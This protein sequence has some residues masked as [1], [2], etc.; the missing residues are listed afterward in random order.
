MARLNHSTIA[1]GARFSTGRNRSATYTAPVSIPSSLFRSVTE[2]I[3]SLRRYDIRT[4]NIPSVLAHEASRVFSDRLVGAESR[5]E[6]ERIV[7]EYLKGPWRINPEKVESVYTV[8]AGV[9][10]GRQSS[11]TGSAV[12]DRRPLVTL[13][14]LIHVRSTEALPEQRLS[15]S[16]QIVSFQLIDLVSSHW[17]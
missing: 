14:L 7:A 6:F 17:F 10:D 8:W 16:D 12:S 2:W 5:A 9:G 15:G 11:R 3:Q 13:L 4:E 1:E